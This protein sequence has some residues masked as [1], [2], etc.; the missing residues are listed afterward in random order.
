MIAVP[1]TAVAFDDKGS[2]LYT[3]ANVTLKAWN[4]AKG[5]MLI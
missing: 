1:V 2:M 5:G 4:M 3:A